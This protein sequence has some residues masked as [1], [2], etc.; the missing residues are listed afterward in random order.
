MDVITIEQI[1]RCATNV[2]PTTIQAIIK[3]ES[4]GRILALNSNR[5]T[6]AT[7]LQPSTKKEAIAM[8]RAEIRAGNSVDIGLMQVNS[9]NL[10]GLELH[11]TK[12]FNVCENIKAGSRILFNDYA[13]AVKEYG[14]G[15]RALQAAISSY[16]TGDFS[17]GY[18]NGYVAKYYNQQPQTPV[19]ADAYS[20]PP[21]V[22]I[23]F[24]PDRELFNNS[25][26]R[27]L[28]NE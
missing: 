15:Q 26:E 10:A 23:S 7:Q 13:R 22:T 19:R 8:A 5:S 18:K 20:A 3:N 25:V 14:V 21:D 9:L 4:G 27:R 24:T 1:E 11:I 12:A 6:G 28:Q 17:A 2:H 16:N